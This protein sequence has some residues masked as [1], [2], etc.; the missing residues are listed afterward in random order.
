M[1]RYGVTGTSLPY[2]VILCMHR[3]RVSFSKNTSYSVLLRNYS[4]ELAVLRLGV[5]GIYPLG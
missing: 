5:G 1:Y 3:S 2:I 4:T